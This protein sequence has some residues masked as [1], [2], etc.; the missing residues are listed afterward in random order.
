MTIHVTPAASTAGTIRLSRVIG[1]HKNRPSADETAGTMGLWEE[2]AQPGEGPPMHI[3]HRDED[4]F[5]VMEGQVRFRCS[6]DALEG[7]SGTTAVLPRGVPHTWQCI[8]DTRGRMLV[9]VTPGGFE[10]FF[11]DLEALPHPDPVI[12]AAPAA[13]Y[14]LKCCVPSN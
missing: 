9:T 4:V 2:V 3:R 12:I 14:D 8:G 6:D 13:P 7:G 11:L 5:F 10:R 1:H